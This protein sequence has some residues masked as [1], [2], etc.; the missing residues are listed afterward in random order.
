MN[1]IGGTIVLGSTLFLLG[2][3]IGTVALTLKHSPK[4]KQRR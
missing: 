4:R 2:A 1:L 3:T